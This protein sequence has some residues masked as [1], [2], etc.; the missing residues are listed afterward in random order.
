MMAHAKHTVTE[1]SAERDYLL[2]ALDDL[3]VDHEAG[4]FTDEDYAAL[5]ESYVRRAADTIRALQILEAQGDRRSLR[6]DDAPRVARFRRFLGRRKVRRSLI[7]IASLCGVALAL[8]VAMQ[9]AGVRL[10][11]QYATGSV[12]VPLSVEVQRELTEANEFAFED[13]LVDA[14]ATYD[15]VL[16][17]VP[18]QPEALAYRGWLERLSGIAGDNRATFDAGDASIKEAVQKDPRYADA[19]GFYVIVSFEDTRSIAAGEKA[20]AAFVS[21]KPSSSLLASIGAQMAASFS[22][23]GVPIPRLLAKYATSGTG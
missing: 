22:S 23:M 7:A 19:Q 21:D 20:Y 18:S 11:G 13:N 6:A 5:R 1:L 12:S 3:E 14:I 9:L 2:G 16:A 4:A 8:V 10:P 17:Q 15:T